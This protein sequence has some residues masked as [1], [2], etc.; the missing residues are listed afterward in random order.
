[1]DSTGECSYLGFDWTKPTLL[2]L[3]AEASGLSSEAARKAD[4]IIRIEMKKPV[5]S[6]NL[7]VSAGVVLFEAVRQNRLSDG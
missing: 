4:H 7:A 1:M 5:E 2:I 3:G 6:L